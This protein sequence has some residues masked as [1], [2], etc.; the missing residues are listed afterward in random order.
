MYLTAKKI[1]TME[2]Q[3]FSPGA[4]EIRDGRIQKIGTPEIIPQGTIPKKLD[5]LVVLPAFVNA[6]CH[7][8]LTAMG[9]IPFSGEKP[10][11][12]SWIQDVIRKRNALAVDT[13]ETGVREGID[14]L[15]RSGVATLGNHTY[16]NGPIQPILDSPLQGRLFGEVV[17]IIPE[18]AEDI[19]SH[20]KEIKK[21]LHHPRWT[22]HPSPH[23][24]H[25][26]FPDVLLKVLKEEEP[27]LSCHLAESKAEDD[28]FKNKNGE[29]MDFMV[30][31][32][33]IKGHTGSSGLQYLS[34]HADISKLLI[35]HGNFLSDEDLDL[36]GRHSLSIVHCPGSHVYF[37][38]P[39]FPIQKL[40]KQGLNIALG[41]DSLAS[42]T[43]LNFL[44]ELTLLKKNHPDL[45]MDFILR[46]ATINGAKALRMENQ[47]GS[48]CV[49]K[50]ADLIGLSFRGSLEKTISEA[51]RVDWMTI[52]GMEIEA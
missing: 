42:N 18:I 12:I 27:P 21:N 34:Q 49:G 19:Y 2:N 15:L 11:F 23:A 37:G 39:P 17:G 36:I 7:L 48:I 45:S 28:Y 50:K 3:N 4:I 43:D 44:S 24:V 31:R 35:I 38:H 20:F 1:L 41:T 30:Q 33:L 6:H 22:L 40:I 29:M 25:S 26:V 14:K 13:M 47:T 46:M 5:D 9:P 10:N 8:E 32:G 51:Q 52:N 16:F